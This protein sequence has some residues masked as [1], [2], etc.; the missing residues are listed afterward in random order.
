MAKWIKIEKPWH[1]LSVHAILFNKIDFFA[2]RSDSWGISIEYN[3]YERGIIF[4][5]LN[6]YAGFEVW[7]SD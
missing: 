4:K 2:G 5:I 3:P 6:F 1:K 7:H